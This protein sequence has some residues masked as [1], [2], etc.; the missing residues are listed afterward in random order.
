[1]HRL[2]QHQKIPRVRLR[3]EGLEDTRRSAK[4]SPTTCSENRSRE[5]G[6]HW[7]WTIGL[8]IPLSVLAVHT[9]QV[10]AGEQHIWCQEEAFNFKLLPFCGSG[11][12]FLLEGSSKTMF[13]SHLQQ[14][15]TFNKHWNPSLLQ[16][17]GKQGSKAR[18]WCLNLKVLQGDHIAAR[19]IL[20]NLIKSKRIEFWPK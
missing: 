15:S 13:G 17:K 9:L 1:M 20:F 12:S 10:S 8:N 14:T 6:K 11:L 4:L 18:W 7:A 19:K 3:S 2:F 5:L 16:S